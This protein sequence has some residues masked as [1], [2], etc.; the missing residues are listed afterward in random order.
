M[1]CECGGNVEWDEQGG[2]VCTACG[3]VV[4]SPQTQLVSH[5]DSQTSVL[6]KGQH[7]FAVKSIRSNYPIPEQS[8][9]ARTRR[10]T[11]A[12]HQYIDD[13]ARNLQ[14]ASL[15]S[16]AQN[17][18]DNA[19]ASGAF[20]WGRKANLIAGAA[21]SI[22]MR[23]SGRPESLQDIAIL[24]GEETTHLQRAFLAI[25]S[26]LKISSRPSDAHAHITALRSKIEMALQSDCKLSPAHVSILKSVDMNN[27]LQTG[28]SLIDLLSRTPSD[29]PPAPTA[30]ATFLFSV[31]AETRAILPKLNEICGFVAQHCHIGKETVVR[32]YQAL[33]HIFMGW[34][35]S[36]PWYA[37]PHEGRVTKRLMLARGL[38]DM[39][40][41]KNTTWKKTLEENR[42]VLPSFTA[43]DS[44]GTR[45]ESGFSG[46]GQKRGATFISA[47][48]EPPPR[49]LM[50]KRRRH[51]LG[52]AQH[53]LIDPQNA[54][55]PFVPSPNESQPVPSFQDAK[56]GLPL[57]TFILA[58]P[59]SGTHL[60]RLPTRLQ[61]L[62]LA[63]GGSGLDE[64][65]DD[66]LFED[67]EYENMLRNDEEKLSFL[68]LWELN[69]GDEI[70]AQKSRTL[71][72][73]TV[74]AEGQSK[75]I[76]AQAVAKFLS[77]D[78]G[79]H[80]AGLIAMDDEKGDDDDDTPL[81][82]L[83][84]LKQDDNDDD[85]GNEEDIIDSRYEEET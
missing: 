74:K 59:N 73:E 71:E 9:E 35:E 11:L 19:M 69:G 42:P 63:R 29:I 44:I 81:I 21:L 26:V 31:E 72:K 1:L 10:N 83:Q 30:G 39:I 24:L 15:S 68:H 47:E 8:T 5:Y 34:M 27:V 36:L 16:R 49:P 40:G 60:K 4:E 77:Q 51:P 85:V 56:V 78:H 52:D 12:L 7:F 53:F 45:G 32:R 61:L 75:R 6:H 62:S 64:I 48:H 14:A 43:D 18:F 33:E 55:L 23:E 22:A 38:K 57:T 80:L 17:I 58:G 84:S 28:R 20:R 2:A 37:T 41:W 70:L 65:P 66:D 67:G 79:D 25:I 76:D 82:G 50:K 54:P 13:L 46:A 3:T